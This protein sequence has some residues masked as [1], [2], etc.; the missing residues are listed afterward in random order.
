MSPLRGFRGYFTPRPH[1]GI[2]GN[3]WA[4]AREST[5]PTLM[6]TSALLEYCAAF[7]R[8]AVRQRPP[9]PR[10]QRTRSSPSARRSPLTRHPLG[11]RITAVVAVALAL[12]TACSTQPRSTTQEERTVVEYCDLVAQPA[13]YLGQVVRVRATY[14]AGYETSIF[15]GEHCEPRT[16]VE[17]DDHWR[18][19][20]SSG[21]I[22][23]Y[24]DLPS[25][26]SDLGTR[27]VGV[28]AVGALSGSG[29]REFGHLACCGFQFRVLA[30]DE[31]GKATLHELP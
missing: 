18:E 19:N 11:G 16:W 30:F 8:Q 23:K 22:R 6:K 31:V 2:S 29:V 13:K 10:V 24:S 3:C 28:V 27:E 15:V 14:Y 20:T 9:N 7:R 12:S 25:L 1:N 21:V 4:M 26:Q 17:F 5:G